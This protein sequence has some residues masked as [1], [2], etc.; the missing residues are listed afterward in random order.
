MEICKNCKTKLDDGV[1]INSRTKCKNPV[2][3]NSLIGVRFLSGYFE[4]EVMKRHSDEDFY[5]CDGR[6]ANRLK[7]RIY[8]HEYIVNNYL[9]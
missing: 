5:Y 8:S 4:F 7:D 6:G 1:H 3:M 2:P 9:S